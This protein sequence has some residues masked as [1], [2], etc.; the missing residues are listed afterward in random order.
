MAN[1]SNRKAVEN[2]V[3]GSMWTPDNTDADPKKNVIVT[4]FDGE[5]VEYGFAHIDQVFYL[6]TESFINAYSLSTNTSG[7]N[8]DELLAQLRTS[9]IALKAA[10]Q[11]DKVYAMLDAMGV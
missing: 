9:L 6:T 1:V 11:G 5:I 2:L 4:D 7:F 10:G 3:I 8:K